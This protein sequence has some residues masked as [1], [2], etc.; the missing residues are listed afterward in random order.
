MGDTKNTMPKIWITY[1]LA[2]F[3]FGLCLASISAI[4]LVVYGSANP[5]PT[6]TPLP[7][8]TIAAQAILNQAYQALHENPQQVLDILEPHLEEF[9]NPDDLA[10]ALKYMGSAELSLG[11]YQLSTAYFERLIQISPTP[12][13]YMALA[14]IYDAGGDLEKAAEYYMVY[15]NSDDPALTDDLRTMVQARVDE[16]Q[17][18]LTGPVSTPVP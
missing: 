12:E 6:Q 5:P 2:G 15:L 1:G 13:N 7:T 4:S 8:P 9:T 11:H 3:L 17:L 18:T 14:R 16:I 10:T